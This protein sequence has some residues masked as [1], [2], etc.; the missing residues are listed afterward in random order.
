VAQFVMV[1]EVFIAERDGEHPLPHQGRHLVL[2]QVLPS[3]IAKAPAK[4]FHQSNRP[5][6]SAKQQRAHIRRHQSGIER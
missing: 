4:T 2:D 3:I 6:G 5:I 1:I